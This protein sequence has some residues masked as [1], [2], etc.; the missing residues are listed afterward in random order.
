MGLSGSFSWCACWVVFALGYQGSA[1]F[2]F[3]YA[4]HWVGEPARSTALRN[5]A[6]GHGKG[7]ADCAA[8][9]E[10]FQRFVI[11]HRDS[12]VSSSEFRDLNRTRQVI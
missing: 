5:P 11:G 9:A 12:P 10:M 8:G 3:Q 4:L 1:R 7:I 2:F 6:A